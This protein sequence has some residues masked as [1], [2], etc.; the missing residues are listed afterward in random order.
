MINTSI[1]YVQLF[2]RQHRAMSTLLE[3]KTLQYRLSRT[4]QGLENI[5]GGT[6][7]YKVLFESVDETDEETLSNENE[8]LAEVGASEDTSLD[9]TVEP[10]EEEAPKIERS[11]PEELTRTL[12]FLRRR[13]Y[14]YADTVSKLS[15][16]MNIVVIQQVAQI[17]ELTKDLD[18]ENYSGSS[19][20]PVPDQFLDISAKVTHIADSLRTHNTEKFLSDAKDPEEVDLFDMVFSPKIKELFTELGIV[21]TEAGMPSFEGFDKFASTLMTGDLKRW[22]DYLDKLVELI[23]E[24]SM[25]SVVAY[26]HKLADSIG[27]LIEA[28]T[29]SEFIYPSLNLLV[30]TSQQLVLVELSAK[31]YIVRVIG[32]LKKSLDRYSK[33][34]DTSD[35][36]LF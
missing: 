3:T 28:Q 11:T 16:E 6:E 26:I 10:E 2:G 12:Q 34:L 24:L 19:S 31:S 9:K 33:M 29:L 15:E 21:K 36:A 7:V 14:E 13:L 4:L 22:L 27:A 35:L 8:E 30:S 32:E 20:I 23:K 25:E 1:N 18:T 17:S 5:Y